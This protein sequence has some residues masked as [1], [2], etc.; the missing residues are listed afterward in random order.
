[1]KNTYKTIQLE[2][3][4]GVITLTL[5]RPE[6]HN[7]MNVEMLIELNS[8]MEEIKESKA[9]ILLLK[10]N[11]PVF[12]AG[13]DIKMMLQDD[14]KLFETVMNSITNIVLTLYTLP[15]I[16]ISA[17]HGAAAGLGLSLALA[18]DYVYAQPSTKIAMNFIK[19][20]LIPDGA[21]HFFLKNRL[22]EIMAKHLIWEGKTV[23][24]SEAKNLGLVDIVE[25]K[26]EQA[27]LS[28]LQQLKS[29]PLQ[30]MIETKSIYTQASSTELK[31]V[32]QLEKSGQSRMR[33]TNDHQ[34][35]I[36]AFLEKRVPNFNG[37]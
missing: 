31:T 28:K 16:T 34:E 36:R 12:S 25:E 29:S 22:G 18:S 35:G 3:V 20:G 8:V 17:L 6:S 23:T 21:G 27:I 13:G 11:G 24:G 5:N 37:E 30:A 10:G 4:N 19:I 26:L 2:E 9:K 7:A 33:Q 32:L 1:M 15:K 14:P